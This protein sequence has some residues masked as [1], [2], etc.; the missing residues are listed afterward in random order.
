MRQALSQDP[1]AVY[2][3][4]LPLKRDASGIHLAW[5]SS[6]HLLANGV[7]DLIEGTHTGTITPEGSN[8]LLMGRLARPGGLTP[9][10]A[11]VAPGTSGP[12]IWP[13]KAAPNPL[14]TEIPLPGMATQQEIVK[15]LDAG[16]GTSD[17]YNTKT[18]Q[19]TESGG[20][21]EVPPPRPARGTPPTLD[22]NGNPIP[23]PPPPAGAPDPSFSSRMAQRRAK[24]AAE[25]AAKNPP[26]PPPT[27]DAQTAQPQPPPPP[28]PEPPLSGK[29]AT[30]GFKLGGAAAGA[31]AGAT[32]GPLFGMLGDHAGGA[33][34]G[35]LLG[36]YAGDLARHLIGA[37]GPQVAAAMLDQA[38]ITNWRNALGN[39]MLLQPWRSV[40]Q[41]PST[42]A[43]L[44]YQQTPNSLAT[45]PSPAPNRQ[46][47]LPQYA[48]SA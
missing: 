16:R 17:P 40:A 8:A 41:D 25:E 13:F 23:A 28:E 7:L 34:L 46:I 30:A 21:K 39:S 44:L 29:G 48:P 1:K 22:E 4:V 43:N 11:A 3:D 45:Q 12:G 33:L 10:P 20:R 32:L 47:L 24:W 6:M 35:A 14:N 9:N 15:G 18:Y 2:G 19:T 38:G 27:I 36:P 5:P 37:Y 42:G 31:A 26:E